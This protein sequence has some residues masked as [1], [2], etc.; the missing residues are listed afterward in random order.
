[1]FNFIKKLF[2]PKAAPSASPTSGWS[3]ITGN[4]D[5]WVQDHEVSVV[6]DHEKEVARLC[7]TYPVFADA[8]H[9]WNLARKAKKKGSAAVRDNMEKIMRDVRN[10]EL[11]RDMGK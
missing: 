10:S 8:Y 3:G 4:V 9:V 11:M 2:R 1:M 7:S 6:P 5:S